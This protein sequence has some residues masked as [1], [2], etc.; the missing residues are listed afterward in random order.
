MGLSFDKDWKARPDS[1]G[2][3]VSEWLANTGRERANRQRQAEAKKNGN[4]PPEILTDRQARGADRV[5]RGGRQSR[6]GK[7]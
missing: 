3:K 5:I 6:G 4:P 7:K 2:E 1:T